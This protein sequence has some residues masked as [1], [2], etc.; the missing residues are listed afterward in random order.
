[1][2]GF[3]SREEMGSL[4][5]HT[6]Y[7]TPA[8]RQGFIARLME[9]G[10]L[11]NYE[12]MLQRRDGSPLWLL[13]NVSLVEDATGAVIEGTVIDITEWKKGQAERLLLSAAID[14]AHDAVVV[15]DPQGDILYVNPAFEAITGYSREEVIGKNPRILKSGVQDQAFYERLWASIA[16]G[17]TWSGRLVNRRKDGALFTEHTIISPVQD[18]AGAITAYVALKRDVT[19]EIDL[20]RRLDEA[21]TLE[22]IGMIAGG[23]AHEVRNPLF[24][25]S[26]V[27]AA[28]NK[29]LG[30]NPDLKPYLDHIGNHVQRLSQLM[31]DLLALGRPVDRAQFAPLELGAAV[32]AAGHEVCAAHPER[33]GRLRVKAEG[34]MVVQ[35]LEPKLRQ[36][37]SNILQNAFHFSPTDGTVE[38]TLWQ[39]GS[40]AFV[41]MADHGPGIPVE[42]LPKLFEPFQSRRKGGTGLG[43]ALV[44]KIVMAHGG[45]VE[46]ANRTDGPGAEFT[47]SLPLA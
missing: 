27:S 43:L 12:E 26:T 21:R 28:L 42:M 40:R 38:V 11:T 6:L 4:L 19:Q 1:M 17:G 46:G 3:Q 9:D 10:H 44:Q 37:F 14:Q 15:A 45:T 32:A 25:I 33:E 8:D 22:T 35:G 7:E 41:K 20:E 18:G 2:F 5:A 47:V 36:V 16:A 13:E 29:K 30:D 39:E 34:I 23:V 24:A 31:D